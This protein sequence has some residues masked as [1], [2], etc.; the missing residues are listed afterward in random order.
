MQCPAEIWT[1]ISNLVKKREEEDRSCLNVKIEDID[2]KMM[3]CL[4]LLKIL[5]KQWWRHFLFLHARDN[6]FGLLSFLPDSLNL[7][8]LLKTSLDLNIFCG[9]NYN[10]QSPKRIGKMYEKCEKTL[11]WP[12]PPAFLGRDSFINDVTG[13]VIFF[14]ERDGAQWSAGERKRPQISKLQSISQIW[15]RGHP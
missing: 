1:V 4:S 12:P 15:A 9:E 2:K 7:F 10:K 14:E 13:M 8:C 6:I 5:I 11:W 3:F